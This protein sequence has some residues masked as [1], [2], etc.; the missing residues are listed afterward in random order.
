MGIVGAASVMS[1]IANADRAFTLEAR[2]V[3]RA[4]AAVVP[5]ALD[6][7]GHATRAEPFP[8][9]GKRRGEGL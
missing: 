1:N 7:P 2:I 5:S 8:I 3:R 6:A 9:I 4:P